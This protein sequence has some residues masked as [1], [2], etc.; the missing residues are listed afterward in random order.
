MFCVITLKSVWPLKLRFPSAFQKLSTRGTLVLLWLILSQSRLSWTKHLWLLFDLLALLEFHEGSLLF[1]LLYYMI[2]IRILLL[3]HPGRSIDKYISILIGQVFRLSLQVLFILVTSRSIGAIALLYLR[4]ALCWDLWLVW[5][6][7]VYDF[8][9]DHNVKLQGFLS[10]D[11]SLIFW[12][13]S[14]LI[15]GLCCFSVCDF[16]WCK[17]AH[18]IIYLLSPLRFHRGAQV[19]LR[20][21]IMRR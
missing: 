18:L 5:R 1:F 6:A 11:P 7:I 15:D 21:E 8:T 19:L 2:V 3:E 10:V 12:S 16:L 13:F 9:H 4:E 17:F 14:L 20:W